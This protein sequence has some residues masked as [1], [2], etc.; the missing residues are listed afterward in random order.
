MA[1]GVRKSLVGERFGKLTVRSY[2]GADKFRNS[3]WKCECDCGREIVAYGTLLTRGKIVS[4]GQCDS[5][6]AKNPKP[7]EEELIDTS[8]VGKRYGRLVVNEVYLKLVSEKVGRK[9]YAKCKCDCGNDFEVL[10]T[11]LKNG[12]TLSCG[13]LRKEKAENTKFLLSDDFIG[14]RFGKLTVVNYDDSL[15]KWKCKCDCGNEIYLKKG[16]LTNNGYRS[17]GNCNG[18]KSRNRR[19]REEMENGE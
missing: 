15:K 5:K 6:R 17:C 13:C 18:K 14:Q 10:A 1:R 16:N 9:M 2:E 11:S 8:M 7:T 12:K 3:T 4:C 19:T